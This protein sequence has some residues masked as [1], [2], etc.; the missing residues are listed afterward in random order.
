MTWLHPAPGLLAA[1][2]ED[3]E[4][5]W[6][7]GW[8]EALCELNGPKFT[9]RHRKRGGRSRRAAPL[10]HPHDDRAIRPRAGYRLRD[11][12]EHFTLTGPLGLLLDSERDL[13]SDGRFVIFETGVQVDGRALNAR[14]FS[15]LWRGITCVRTDT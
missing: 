12:L 8:F 9:L 5:T 13:L 7:V 4:F 6:A 15:G 1:L 11:A 10:A 14:A 3:G 2:D